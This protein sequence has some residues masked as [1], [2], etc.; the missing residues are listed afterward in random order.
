MCGPYTYVHFSVSLEARGRE[1]AGYLVV[2]EEHVVGVPVPHVDA[3]VR[4]VGDAVHANLE[5]ARAELLGLGA[6]SSDDLLDV[7]ELAKDVGARGKGDE[8]RLRRDEREE[9]VEPETDAVRILVRRSGDGDPVV[10]V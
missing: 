9:V 2:R 10:H 3:A 4:R 5:L 8:A 7:H 1:H 6:Q